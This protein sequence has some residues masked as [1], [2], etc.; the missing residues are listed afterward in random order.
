[1]KIHPNAALTPRQR[2]RMVTRIDGGM[3]ISHAAAEFRVS[4][5]TA[6]KW[7]NRYQDGDDRLTD[8]PSVPGSTP[9]RTDPDVEAAVID[10][11][12]RHGWGAATL[13]NHTGVA[14]S[15]CWR[16]VVR[17]GLDDRRHRYRPDDAH[18]PPDCNRYERDNPGELVHVDTK[19][20]GRIPDGGGWRVH[21]RGNA[22]PK[23]HVGSEHLHAAVDDHSRL[24]YVELL[25]TRDAADCTGFWRRANAWFADQGITVQQV[26]T[27]NAWAYTKSHD[28]AQALEDTNID[29]LTIKPYRP[30]TNG[31]VERFN[32]TLAEQWAYAYFYDS[33]QA[34]HQSLDPWVHWYN[35]HRDHTALGDNPPMTRV[36]NA[37]VCYI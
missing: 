22:G 23:Q 19:K 6:T 20:L 24:A 32:R 18:G 16:I 25:P 17:A 31:K 34:R 14:S 29:H 37:A 33:N 30:Q 36:N 10:L 26:M 3:P 2:R 1:M 4:R 35:H 27:D 11:R 28:F 15:T 5:Q 21:G 8:R 12:R 7:W 13:A 9:H